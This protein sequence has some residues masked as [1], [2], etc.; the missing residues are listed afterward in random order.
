M[1]NPERARSGKPHL[2]P[3]QQ[4]YNKIDNDR[5]SYCRVFKLDH[6]RRGKFPFLP[7][8]PNA[9]KI[10]CIVFYEPA[11]SPASKVEMVWAETPV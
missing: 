11:A 10:A 6:Q 8:C 2:N 7:S 3:N 4:R 1:P 5:R 9:H